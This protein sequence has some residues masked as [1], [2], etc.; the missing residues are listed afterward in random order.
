MEPCNRRLSGNQTRVERILRL[1]GAIKVVYVGIPEPDTF[2]SENTGRK[3]LE[4]AG[5]AVRLV[6]RMEHRIAAVSTSGHVP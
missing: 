6:E 2:V 4:D 1:A 5:V 3:R